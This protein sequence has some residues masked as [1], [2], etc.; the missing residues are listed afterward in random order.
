MTVD[1]RIHGAQQVLVGDRLA[2]DAGQA[3]GFEPAQHAEFGVRVAQAVEHHHADQGFDV[4]GVAGAP[5][6][7]AQAIEAERTPQLR[8]R[9]DVA[10]VACRFEVHDRCKC[11]TRGTAQP[12]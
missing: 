2:H 3:N 12:A 9:P 11:S 4:D 1:Q 8:E 10:E 7:S 5:K 6:Q